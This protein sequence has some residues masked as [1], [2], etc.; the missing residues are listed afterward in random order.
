M[1]RDAWQGSHWSTNS[2][3]TGMTRPGR[4]PT[5]KAGGE[6]GCAAL[7]AYAKCLLVGWLVA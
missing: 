7:E 6:L 1:S 2:E 5:E 3:V 4:I